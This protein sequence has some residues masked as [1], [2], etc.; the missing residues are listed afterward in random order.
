MR[1]GECVAASAWRSSGQGGKEFVALDLR[2][3]AAATVMRIHS[4]DPRIATNVHVAGESDL[5][6]KRENELDGAAGFQVRFDQEIEAAEADVAGLAR[7]F[8]N[9]VSCGESH[10]Q[11]KHH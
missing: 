1:G 11:G 3:H 7:F 9:S 10:S 2:G 8:R 6:R 4:E 5:L